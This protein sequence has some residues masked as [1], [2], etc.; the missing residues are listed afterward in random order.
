M[1]AANNTRRGS[2]AA[3]AF[4]PE[5]EEAVRAL[6]DYLDRALDAPKMAVID[7][8]LAKCAP[9]REHA[10]FERALIDRIRG[11]RR[12]H[13]DPVALRVRVLAALR[14]AGLARQ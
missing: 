10:R 11:L 13:H 12:E 9:C 7:D 5:C 8:H 2:L 14:D 6:W 4:P 1:S 3:I